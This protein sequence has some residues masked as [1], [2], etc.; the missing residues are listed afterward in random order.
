MPYDYSALPRRRATSISS[1]PARSPA[2]RCASAPAAP[3]RTAAQ[4]F[5]GRRSARC[6]TRIRGR[7]RSLRAAQVLEQLRSRWHD[8]RARHRPRKS[9]AVSCAASSKS[10]R[11]IR[12]DDI[13]DQARARRTA[14]LK[15]FD[16]IIFVARIGVEKGKPKNDGTRREL[17]GQKHHRR[18]HH[19]GQKRLASGRSAATL[20][21]RQC[22]RGRVA[23]AVRDAC[24]GHHETGVGVIDDPTMRVAGLTGRDRGCMAAAGNRRRHRRGAWGR[25]A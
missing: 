17:S 25:R 3:A 10:A 7:R 21:R 19:A 9:A 12:P 16:N 5:Q 14:D 8:R 20:Q 11:N 6:S 18:R 1:R 13:S 4:A 24:P 15:D 23:S 2:C 22:R